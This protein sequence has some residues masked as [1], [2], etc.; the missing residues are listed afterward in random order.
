M[1]NSLS[2]AKKIPAIIIAI[3]II[4]VSTTGI[5]SY[6]KAESA[7]ELEVANKLDAVLHDRKLALGNWL[8]AIEGDLNVQAENPTIQEALKAFVGAWNVVK[9]NP[10]E[11]LQRI[12]ITEN[13]NPLGQ[14]ENLDAGQD[15]SNYS[16]YHLRYHPYL[17]SFLRNRGYYD[18]FLFDTKGN[19]VYSVF[20]ELDYATNLV[21]GQWAGSDL[22]KAFQEAHKN[23]QNPKFNAFLDFKPYAPSNDAPASFISKPMFDARGTYIGVL[24]FQMPLEKLNTM[25]QQ[26]TGMGETGETYLIGADKLMRSDSRFSEESTILKRKVDTE[27]VRKAFSGEAGSL[28]GKN[29]RGVDVLANFDQIE[30]KGTTWAVIAEIDIVEAFAE[31]YELRNALLIG[32]LIGISVLVV[33]GVYVGRGIARPIGQMTSAM[34]SLAD[35]NLDEEIPSADRQDEIGA[36]AIAVQVFKDNAIHNKQMESE[37]AEQKKIS[38]ERE[39]AAQQEAISNERQ[40]VNDVFGE[41]MSAIAAKEL[42]HRITKEL[43]DAYH[44]LRDDFNRSIEE[45]SSTI[46]NIGSASGQI[47]SGSKEIHTAADNLARRTEQQAVAVEETAAALEETTTAMKTSTESAKEAS[48][49][50]ATTKGNAEKSGEIVKQAISAMGK[51]EKSADEIANIIGVIDDIAFQTNLLALNAGVEAARAGESGKGFAVVAQE[52]RELAQRSAN[53]AKEISKL[54]TTSSEDVI[55]GASLVNETG[56]E[57]EVIVSSVKEIND[58]VVSIAAAASEQ[59]LGLQEINQS[60]NSIDQGTQQNAAVAEQ[61]TAASH[62]LSE[63][64]IKIDGMLREFNT[65]KSGM[66]QRP[67]VASAQNTPQPSPARALNRQVANSFNGNAAV[68]VEDNSWEEF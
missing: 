36:M 12:Y 55:A 59:S 1:L 16:Y 17:R 10:Q 18:I 42:G 32:L 21:T 63:E 33:I 67:E 30:F 9:G 29:Y 26:K 54:I 31:V 53:A 37:K 64:V 49:L 46:N 3:A 68:A 48:D 61:S 56:A 7:I 38:E 20:K 47:L 45:L 66:S 22:G 15:G 52:V 6:F 27:Q 19:L 51:I 60:V 50:V 4:A 23:S 11:T 44:S 8:D 58:H 2:I 28:I 13:P 65:G 14:K 35:G 57:L 40:L 25:M 24:A 43:P 41:A 62:S 39:K 34:K 5:F